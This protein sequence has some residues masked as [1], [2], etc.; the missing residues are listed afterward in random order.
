VVNEFVAEEDSCASTSEDVREG[1]G[2]SCD[3][4]DV[5]L[6]AVEEGDESDIDDDFSDNDSV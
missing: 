5:E 1:G 3:V 2:F 4:V 6:S